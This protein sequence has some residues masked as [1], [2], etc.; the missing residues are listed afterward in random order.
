MSLRIQEYKSNIAVLFV[1]LIPIAFTMFIFGFTIGKKGWLQNID[2]L[3]R[4]IKKPVLW[5][6][7]L[8]NVYRVIFL[9]FLWETEIW[10]D[11]FWRTL[12]IYLMQLCDALMAL[13]YIW[14]LAYGYQFSFWQ[15]L[16]SPLQYAGRMALTNYLLQSFIG[17]LIFSSAGL[18]WYG[19]CC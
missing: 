7:V 8:S 18:Q 16:L 6:A 17:L 13:F 5:I 2:T 1:S 9:F 14:I 19:K 11:S 10:K 4:R 3:V 15:K 12:F